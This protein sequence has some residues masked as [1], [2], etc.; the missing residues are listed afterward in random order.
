MNFTPSQDGHPRATIRIERRIGATEI[1]GALAMAHTAREVR[2]MAKAE[3]ERE[4]RRALERYGD[5]VYCARDHHRDGEWYR[6]V[7]ATVAMFP[8]IESL[9]RRAW[10]EAVAGEGEPR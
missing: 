10:P 6:L 8:E 4:V 7:R 9:A 1:V 2:E 5:H 3:A